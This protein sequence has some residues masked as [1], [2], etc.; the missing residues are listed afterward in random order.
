M[1]SSRLVRGVLRLGLVA[2][3][4][5]AG[6]LIWGVAPAVADTGAAPA[7]GVTVSVQLGPLTSAPI[8]IPP[9][10]LPDGGTTTVTATVLPVTGTPSPVALPFIT[11]PAPT[12]PISQPTATGASGAPG[13]SGDVCIG[14]AVLTDTDLTP[15]TT[16]TALTDNPGIDPVTGTQSTGSTGVSGSGSGGNGNL[17]TPLGTLPFTGLDAGAMVLFALALAGSGVAIRRLRAE[18]RVDANA[19]NGSKDLF[20][21]TSIR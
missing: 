13:T 17:A 21:T 9:I 10:S 1:T 2:G 11:I 8:T 16:S 20:G 14:A 12:G 4:L 7:A 19:A 18:H 3:G 5:T 15:C 6:A